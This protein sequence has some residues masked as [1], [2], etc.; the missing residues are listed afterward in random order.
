MKI[1]LQ[2]TADS[3]DNN[4]GQ[5]AVHEGGKEVVAEMASRKHRLA[6]VAGLCGVIILGIVVAVL[7]VFVGGSFK[8][9]SESS[10][11]A[12]DFTNVGTDSDTRISPS[13]A[14]QRNTASPTLSHITETVAPITQVTL[15]PSINAT[16]APTVS[17]SP[18]V[19]PSALPTQAPAIPTPEPTMMPNTSPDILPVNYTSPTL[20]TFCVIADVPY[21]DEEARVL[22]TQ[23]RDQMEGCEFLVHLG[24]IMRGENSGFGFEKCLPMCAS[25]TH[26]FVF[27][28]C[29]GEISCTE[30]H[31]IN[32]KAMMLE[33]RV[34]AFIVPGDNE[35]NDC[36]SDAMVEVAWDQ[37]RTYFTNLEDNWNHTLP[38]VRSFDYPEN[39]Y[40]IMK[41]TLIFGLNVVGGRVQDPAEWFTRLTAEVEWI[42]SIVLMNIGLNAD[43]VIIL[44]HAKLTQDH[45]SFSNPL[46]QF[47]RDDL[48]NEVPFLYLHGDGHKYIYNSG[49]LNQPNMLGIQHEGGVRDPI[50]KILAD[51]YHQGSNVYNA[52]QVDRQLE[53]ES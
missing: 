47:V 39:F 40:F 19:V 15:E 13:P 2:H 14:P 46:R 32:I 22:P 41:R 17:N 53:F 30:D 10:S 48:A 20:L 31:Y 7:A 23:I 34:P 27:Y 28:P 44:A 5:F 11:E 43:G 45:I 16:N 37:W 3:S 24:D 50:L 6:L 38:V 51:P 8:D 21:Y 18:S 52:F 36:G 1:E 33:S 4:S 26:S 12:F 42:K 49:F 29:V 25:K 35:W 9:T